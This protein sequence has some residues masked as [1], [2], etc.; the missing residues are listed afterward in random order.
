M[1]LFAP[2]TRVVVWS[3]DRLEEVLDR[4]VHQCRLTMEKKEKAST[5][6]CRL[7]ES[8]L[9]LAGIGCGPL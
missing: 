4:V 7:L 1:T 3:K 9:S 8:K 2:N 5:R 6:G